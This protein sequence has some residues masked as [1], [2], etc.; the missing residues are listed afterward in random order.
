MSDTRVPPALTAEEWTDR[1]AEF[2][3]Y[4]VCLYFYGD[5]DARDG[6]SELQ[7]SSDL[8][9]DVW[10]HVPDELMGAAAALCLHGHPHGFTREMVEAIRNCADVMDAEHG[11]QHKGPDW[12]WSSGEY[13]EPSAIL[14]GQA[15]DLLEALLP[16]ETA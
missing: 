16:P 11:Y 13:G 14:A 12:D 3:R 5:E 15:A 7:V 8:G 2:G 1:T 6:G 9:R 10:T 4:T